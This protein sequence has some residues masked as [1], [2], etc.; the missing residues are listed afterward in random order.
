M[1][2][3]RPLSPVSGGGREATIRARFST[4]N[5]FRALFASAL[6][7]FVASSAH[8]AA[9]VEVRDIV[10]ALTTATAQEPVD[11]RGK[12]L[13]DLDLSN[14]DLKAALFDSSNL[15][16]VNLSSSDLRNVSLT[17]VTLDR[18]QL[19]KA[20]FTK[21]NL[22]GS[23]ILIPAIHLALES[24]IWHAPIFRQSNLEGAWLSGN[25][26]GTDFGAANLKGARFGIR[27]SL[28]RCEFSGANLVGVA[29]Q[30]ARLTYARFL[31]A[32][33]R[34]A[35]FRDAKLI[36]VDFTDADLR[37][38]DFTGADL[39]MAIMDGAK[40]KGAILEKA[41]GLETA[42]GMAQR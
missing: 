34:N 17:G 32:D 33:L 27:S 5:L 37:G 18:A 35:N 9:E 19:T 1:Y 22:R 12:D 40:L 4:Q 36:W 24:H 16:G 13:S 26:D 23:R 2:G 29:F 20:D 30:R 8:S 38:A 39:S 14:L 6:V 25:F 11:L 3:R 10:T 21:A 42:R 7:V 41:V 15:F 28:E 31:M